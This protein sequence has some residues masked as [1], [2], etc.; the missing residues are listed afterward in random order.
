[1]SH[2]IVCHMSLCVS[3]VIDTPLVADFYASEKGAAT[4]PITA[5]TSS[6]TTPADTKQQ[7]AGPHGGP[8]EVN[9]KL[10]TDTTTAGESK[11]QTVGTVHKDVGDVNFDMF[12]TLP[13]RRIGN[14]DEV[15]DAVVWLCM[16]GD[17]VTG[18]DLLVDGG[19]L[20]RATM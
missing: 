20:A 11:P 8:S 5:G 10:E 6:H 9:L 15:A 2:V 16:Q 13:L 17:Y 18:T 3:G 12:K 1:M 4:L 19:I 14:P 7:L